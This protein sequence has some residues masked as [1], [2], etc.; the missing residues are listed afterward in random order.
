MPETEITAE[1]GTSQ[2]VVSREFDA[3]RDLVFRCFTDPDLIPRWLGPRELTTRVEEYDL[4]DGG[5]YR[6]VHVDAEGNEYAF[7]GVFHGDPAPELTVQTFEFEGMPGHVALEA[8]TM[9]ESGG[10]TRVRTLSS[11]QSVEDRDG[12]IASGMEV[13]VRDS[14]ERLAELLTELR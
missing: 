9:T 14:D 8:V 3:P 2:V 5:R 12:I 13:G 7:R 4:K 11:F 1:P 6:Y 10:R